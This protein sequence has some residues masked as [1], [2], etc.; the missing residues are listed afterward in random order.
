V[1]RDSSH[2][3]MVLT[4]ALGQAGSALGSGVSGDAFCG[5]GEKERGQ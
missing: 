4:K 1:A 5:A 3:E 2:R